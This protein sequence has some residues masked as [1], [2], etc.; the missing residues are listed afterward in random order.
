MEILKL[1]TLFIFRAFGD[2]NVK[3]LSYLFEINQAEGMGRHRLK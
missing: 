3:Q 1:M 2:S